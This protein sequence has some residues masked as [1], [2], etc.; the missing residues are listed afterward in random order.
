MRRREIIDILAIM[1][2]SDELKLTFPDSSHLLYSCVLESIL[3]WAG[4][5]LRLGTETFVYQEAVLAYTSVSRRP[6][7]PVQEYPC[8]HDFP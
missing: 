7:F 1:T 6:F 2:V 3:C 4:V 5:N 8:V